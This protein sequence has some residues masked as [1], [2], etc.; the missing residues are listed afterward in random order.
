MKEEKNLLEKIKM[1]IA[2]GIFGIGFGYGLST[3]VYDSKLEMFRQPE[4]MIPG[5]IV[6][7]NDWFNKN[8]PNFKK[9]K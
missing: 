3:S 2:A 8:N 6:E 9:I 5:Y 4:G 1:S 7:I